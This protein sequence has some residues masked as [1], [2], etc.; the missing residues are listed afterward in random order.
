MI[1]PNMLKSY[2]IYILLTIQVTQMILILHSVLSTNINIL[3]IILV[4]TGF[5]ISSLGI[6]ISS[7]DIEENYCFLNL[8]N[9]YIISST[10]LALV[11][12]F[13]PLS[14]NM[15]MFLSFLTIYVCEVF[16]V[17]IIFDKIRE[18]K[19]DIII[20]LLLILFFSWVESGDLFVKVYPLV[21]SFLVCMPMFTV[22]YRWK[23]ISE[24][25]TNYLK[26]IYMTLVVIFIFMN[27]AC[28][29]LDIIDSYIINSFLISI[30][31]L[32]LSMVL[33]GS[34][35]RIVKTIFLNVI[36]NFW[37]YPVLLMIVSLGIS[38]ELINYR[39][40]SV[41]CIMLSIY[42]LEI[43]MISIKNIS[44]NDYNNKYTRLQTIKNLDKSI[45][46]NELIKDYLHDDILQNLILIKKNI[47]DHSTADV[48]LKLIE[49][50]IDSIRHEMQDISPTI[51][52]GSSLKNSYLGLIEYLKNRYKDRV[53]FCEFFCDENL[54]FPYPYNVLTYKFI[55]ELLNNIY[56]HTDSNFADIGISYKDGIINIYSYNDIG[57]IPASVDRKSTRL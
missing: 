11:Y 39:I 21:F 8:I 52:G 29:F 6:C 28:Y 51:L 50:M 22:C 5:I 48:N 9:V 34:R 38:L 19:I 16:I 17:E 23:T 49:E 40:S 25:F 43:S 36:R 18:K 1:R 24:Y 15:L 54:F 12:I 4:C 53:L 27:L 20:V 41:L 31:I 47:I 37:F 3:N 57:H 26:I 56:K 10:Y 42:I 44:P 55:G 35:L 30:N 45:K 46:T 32:I 13:S 7:I 33:I 14:K 2:R